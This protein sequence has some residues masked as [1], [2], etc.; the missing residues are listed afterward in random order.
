[1]DIVGHDAGVVQDRGEL[2]LELRV[3]VEQV[4][5]SKLRK[6]CTVAAVV[7][8]AV[9]VVV[10][11]VMGVVVVA[12][13]V[14]V[15]V[16]VVGVVVAVVM[17]VVVPAGIVAMITTAV[18]MLIAVFGN[19]NADDVVC[20]GSRDFSVDCWIK[21]TRMSEITSILGNDFNC[22]NTPAIR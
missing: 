18:L 5:G 8:V 6:G 1:M 3:R 16:V 9:V 21:T 17:V 11:V 15:V 20:I 22:C 14:G 10:F 7:V 13:M 12:M 4:V 19:P 2:R